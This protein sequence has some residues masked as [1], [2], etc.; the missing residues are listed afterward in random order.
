MT[1]P[2][3]IAILKP[4]LKALDELQN[5]INGALEAGMY[6]TRRNISAALAG[7]AQAS[8]DQAEVEALADAL[9]RW[10]AGLDGA[11]ETD[12]WA[13][14]L[15][16]AILAA[17]YSRA[18]GVPTD[19]STEVPVDAH[20]RADDATEVSSD[21]DLRDDAPSA[22]TSTEEARSFGPHLATADDVIEGRARYA[23]TPGWHA[24]LKILRDES[25]CHCGAPVTYG[26]DG[27]P[28]H[29]RGMC[30]DCDLV[31]CDAYPG[32]CK[33]TDRACGRCGADPAHGFAMVNDVRYCHGDG[34]QDPTCYMQQS[35]CST[36]QSTLLLR[37]GKQDGE[38]V[39]LA[40]GGE[41]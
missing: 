6:E 16:R 7:R 9:V 25:T 29:H 5:V 34:D 15:A 3:P 32:A 12:H 41:R 24:D 33:P 35:S 36:G 27:D 18:P 19:R 26:Y 2:D 28:N 1:E 40:E 8:P 39:S 13:D 17:G 10:E 38:A 37:P 22:G 14:R 20:A 4:M 31:R 23:D 11:N 21:L 30:E